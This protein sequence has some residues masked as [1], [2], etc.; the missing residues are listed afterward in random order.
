MPNLSSCSIVPAKGSIYHWA[1][2]QESPC[3]LQERGRSF[4]RKQF[5]N[6]RKAS[7]TNCSGNG[8]I[9]HL[10]CY[11]CMCVA[12][13]SDQHP[14]ICWMLDELFVITQN[15]GTIHDISKNNHNCSTLSSI[16]LTGILSGIMKIVCH[17]HDMV[18]CPF[19]LEKKRNW[20]PRC[21]V[22]YLPNA[23]LCCLS[24]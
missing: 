6:M 20:S 13:K 8:R 21:F 1:S 11:Q 3:E 22:A 24:W 10:W 12:K 15:L 2:P 23:R 17:F 16:Y 4:F 5:K 19:G 18:A 7:S 14:G 9:L